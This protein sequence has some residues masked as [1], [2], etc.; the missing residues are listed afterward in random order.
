[1]EPYNQ[2]LLKMAQNLDLE[3]FYKLLFYLQIE[4]DFAEKHVFQR[5][6]GPGAVDGI[7]TFKSLKEVR[8][9]GLPILLFSSM[10]NA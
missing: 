3:S 6:D 7:V 2:T 4:H 10:D 9:R 8:I 5:S 1:M